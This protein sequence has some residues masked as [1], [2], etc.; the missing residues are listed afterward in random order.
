VDGGGGL[1]SYPKL[2]ALLGSTVPGP[3]KDASQR[4][5]GRCKSGTPGACGEELCGTVTHQ[6]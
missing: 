4:S 1:Y 5:T 2:E 3:A 6:E